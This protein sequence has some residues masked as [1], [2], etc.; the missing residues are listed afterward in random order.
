MDKR[1]GKTPKNFKDLTGKRFGRLLVTER[2]NNKKYTRWQVYYKVKC[3][4][5]IE[6]I[7]RGTSLKNNT[8]SCGCLQKEKARN[9]GKK[10]AKE[11]GFYGKN[12]VFNSY[13]KSAK[14]RNLSFNLTFEE[15]IEFT[16]NLCYYCNSKPNNIYKIK[17]E[18]GNFVYNGID[19]VN[20]N[21]GYEKNNC[22]TCCSICNYAKLDNT[23]EDFKQWIIKV[24][25]NFAIKENK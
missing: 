20:S 7:V 8:K 23:K 19:R 24:Y 1:I 15:F 2:T 14:S 13:K 12:T 16:Q 5:G 21:E 9:T 11:L 10:F 17:T 3:D 18:S 25:F 22:V 6:K 4:C